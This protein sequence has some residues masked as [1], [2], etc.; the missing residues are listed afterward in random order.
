MLEAVE[1]FWKHKNAI[2]YHKVGIIYDRKLVICSG[3]NVALSTLKYGVKSSKYSS[4][5]DFLENYNPIIKDILFWRAESVVLKG[6]EAI[7]KFFSALDEL[8]ELKKMLKARAIEQDFKV[9][10]NILIKDITKLEDATIKVLNTTGPGRQNECVKIQMPAS[11][12]FRQ[13]FDGLSKFTDRINQ[14]IETLSP[15]EIQ[16]EKLVGD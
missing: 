15:E 3:S 6:E 4:T 13:V 8:I 10:R 14:R 1:D 12:S 9:I 2:E 7:H 16:L 5:R 11:V